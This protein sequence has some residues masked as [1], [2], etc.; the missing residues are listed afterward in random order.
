MYYSIISIRCYYLVSKNSQLTICQWTWKT[1]CP[2]RCQLLICFVV[3][4]VNCYFGCDPKCQ[5]FKN[6]TSKSTFKTELFGPNDC[7]I[8]WSWMSFNLPQDKSTSIRYLWKNHG[9]A[10]DSYCEWQPAWSI[11]CWPSMYNTDRIWILD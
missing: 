2:P 10:D 9:M 5:K 3:T 1:W 11:F 7:K 4:K 8:W 6:P